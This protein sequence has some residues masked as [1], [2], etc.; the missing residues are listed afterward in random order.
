MKRVI[1]IGLG[2]LA[3]IMLPLVLVFSIPASESG[4]RWLCAQAQKRITGLSIG[5]VKGTL[6]G[7]LSLEAVNFE[8][9]TQNLSL[10]SVRLA[11]QPLALLAGRLHIETLTLDAISITLPKPSQ[12][13]SASTF[14]FSQFAVPVAIRV[15][16]LKITRLAFTNSEQTFV[17]NQVELAATLKGNNL[18]LTRLATDAYHVETTVQGQIGLTQNLPLNINAGWQAALPTGEHW[19]GNFRAQ[20]DLL[21]LIINSQS[22]GTF[23]AQLDG[24]LKNLAG[25]PR[26]AV[27]GGWQNLQWPLAGEPA[28]FKSGQ[29]RFTLNG[30]IDAYTITL[31][32]Q[33]NP[34]YL[35]QA[36]LSLTAQG[37]TQAIKLAPL[38]L[39]S[40]DGNLQIGGDIGWQNGI[41]FDVNVAGEHFNPGVLY[42]PLPGQI[43]LDSHLQG[44][45]NNGALA[46]AVDLKRLNGKLKTVAFDGS[47]R[48]QLAGNQLNL[49]NVNLNA[50]KNRLTA[51]GSLGRE[52]A[53]LALDLKFP[54]L[55]GLWPT[56]A[57]SL[58][59]EGT[60]KGAWQNP[61]V[62]FT[63]SGKN[64]SFAPYQ[65]GRLEL[66]VDYHPE[67]AAKSTLSLS[68]DNIRDAAK[69]L[70][71]SV[72]LE[73]SGNPANH[74]ADL[75]LQS[76]SANLELSLA[77]RYGKTGWEGELDRLLLNNPQAGQWQLARPAAIKLKPQSAG[78]DAVFS[79]T[80]LVQAQAHWCTSGKYAANGNFD[81]ASDAKALPTALLQPFLPPQ[82]QLSGA[83]N[84]SAALQKQRGELTGHYRID[85]PEAAVL[86]MPPPSTD[87]LPIRLAE[88]A[89]TIER[90]TVH[91]NLDLSLPAE[92]YVR[93]KLSL[94]LDKQQKIAGSILANVQNF[95]LINAF[96]PQLSELSGLFK[97]DLTVSGTLQKPSWQGNLSLVNT[98]AKVPDL[99]LELRDLNLI[100]YA[101]SDAGSP[102]RIFGSAKSGAG[103]VKLEGMLALDPELEWPL[104]LALTGNDFEISKRTDAQI[105]VSPDLKLMFSPNKGLVSGRLVIPKALISL[106]KLPENAIAVS[107]D[108]R[109][110]GEAQA[111]PKGFASGG[112]DAAIA[113]TLGQNVHFSGQG[114]EAQL[115]GNLR[116]NQSS[117]KTEVVGSVE[118]TKAT[119]K[120]YGQDLTVRKGR[121]IFNGPVDNPWLDVE[122][123]RL[124]KDQKTTAILSV[125]GALSAP[126]TKISADPALPETEALA[127]LVTGQSLD[128]AGQSDS[129]ALAGA[130]LAYGVGQAS[131][132][133]DKLGVDTFELQQGATLQKSLLNIG[134]HLNKDFYV[135][136][137]VG[138]FAKQSVLV[139]K[140]KLTQIFSIETQAGFSQRIKLN[141]EFDS[142]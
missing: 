16:N 45:W 7:R 138:L 81:I 6:L 33:L 1:G 129:S 89:G 25:Q 9:D 126:Q 56:L 73:A 97:A 34:P 137:K 53:E 117:S 109:I 91:S 61:E 82:M 66:A 38:T 112:I 65:T 134:Q 2:L 50:G 28:Q 88:L 101:P 86:A 32:A 68:V 54:N 77:G 46:L 5:K 96:V 10:G 127:Y 85:M 4:T 104:Q 78:F 39:T 95:R 21:K 136:A 13:E 83:I 120:S 122:A 80:C 76:R 60:L 51:N 107:A 27:T 130:A 69:V 118:M 55:K 74:K 94:D 100:A 40:A 106:K 72:K 64:L 140:Q 48:F 110:V 3:V 102:M 11:W 128:Q 41:Q 123:I 58:N 49:D 20:G 24:V 132:L 124:S 63:A 26:F 79:E 84:L 111:Q 98:Q 42:A 18:E 116:L 115:T 44:S 142:D 59:G 131:W 62:K 23:D 87:K 103:L 12:T 99:G 114:L 22:T 71:Q 108:E 47:G 75:T 35:K 15:D 90:N 92:D 31:G 14:D 113:I 8:D 29:G 119:Y 30:S 141:A 135:G 37:S 17:I 70:A 43:N 57:G 19:Q 139:I 67:P 133:T 52:Q 105:A 36:E 93:A 125:T 121:F